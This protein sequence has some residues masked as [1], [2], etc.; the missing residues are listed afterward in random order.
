V[1]RATGVDAAGEAEVPGLMLKDIAWMR[2]IVVDEAD[3]DVH[4]RLLPE[5]DGQIRF[6]IYTDAGG[7]GDAP[8]IHAQGTAVLIEPQLLPDLDLIRLRSECDRISL[9]A[10]QCYQAFNR[11]GLDYGPA[12][13]AIEAVYVGDSKV[14]AK[15]R[16]P[17]CVPPTGAGD[18]ILHPSLMDAALQ[19]TLGLSF[20][21]GD[22]SVS[23]GD[24]KTA[25]PFALGALEMYGPCAA[26]MWAL[27]RYAGGSHGGDTVQ[28]IDLDLCDEHGKVLIRL[29]E[30]SA[31]AL[32][33]EPV[34]EITPVG[35]ILLAPVWKPVTPELRPHT[36]KATPRLLIVGGSREQQ[37]A[38]RDLYPEARDIVLRRDIAEIGA[39]L[40][41]LG[42]I[43]HIVWIAPAQPSPPD[44]SSPNGRG[45]RPYA[46]LIE[47]QEAGVLQLFRLIKALLSH[48]YGDRQ[49]SWT[50][51]TTDAVAVRGQDAVSAAHAAV[52][53]LV[54]SMAKEYPHW[55]VRLVDLDAAAPWPWREL[56]ALPADRNGDAWVQRRGEWFRQEL[57]P[58]RQWPLGES[59]LYR[60]G[61]VYVVIGG[62]GGIGKA[63]SRHIVREHGAQLVWIGRRAEDDA[64][65]ADLDALGAIGP[66]PLYIQADARDRAALQA[67]GERVKAAYGHVHGVVHSA[68]VLLDRTLE[69]MDEARFRTAL[70]TKVDISVRLAEVFAAEPLDFVLFFSAV[71]SFLK[72]PGQSNY[73]AGCTFQDAFAQQLRRAWSCPVKVINWGYWGS[74]GVVSDAFYR[75]RMAAVGIDSI[76]PADGMAALETLF[77]GPLHQLALVK[78]LKPEAMQA[79]ELVNLDAC[80]SVY[81]DSV[82]VEVEALRAYLPGSYP[83]LER[84]KA[85]G[86]PQRDGMDELLI[87]LLWGSLQSL[88]LS[89]DGQVVVDGDGSWPTAAGLLNTYARWWAETVRILEGAGYLRRHGKR[90]TINDPAPIDVDAVW[91]QW[92][93][94]KQEW[95]EDP[96]QKAPVVLVERCLRALPEILTGKRS[97]TDIMFPNGSMELVEGIYQ[98][99]VVADYFNDILGDVVVAY[100]RERLARDGAPG[101]IRILEIGAGTGA[102]TAAVLPKLEPYRVHLREYCYSDISKAF[103]LHAQREYA[104]GRPFLALK[105]F[106]VEQPIAAQGIA[107][108]AYDLAIATNVLHATKNIRRTLANAKAA[109]RKGGLLLLNELNRSALFVHLTFGLLEGWWRYEDGALRL[110]GCPGLAPETWARV[111]REEGFPKLL[112]PAE[113]RHGLGQHIIVAQSDGIVQQEGGEHPAVAGTATADSL[114]SRERAR[115]QGDL[116]VVRTSDVADSL[117][118]RERARVRE[119]GR[120]A[121]PPITSDDVH[122]IDH[123]LLRDKSTALLKRMV[124]ETLNMSPRQIDSTLSLE[125]YGIDSILA[126]RLANAFREV[127]D[128]VSSTLF[129]EVQTIDALVDHFMTT[130]RETLIR[131]VGLEQPRMGAMEGNRTPAATITEQ[132][133]S[134]PAPRPR[135]FNAARR[136]AWAAT[137]VPDELGSGSVVT[138]RRAVFSVQ[139][140]AVIGLS[141][142]YPRARDVG[143]FWQR[144]RAGTNCVGEIPPDRWDWRRFYDAEKGKPGTSYSRWGGFLDDVDMFD[145]LFFQISP[146]E[147]GG[148]DPQERLFLETAY[149]CI[150]DAGYTPATLCSSRKV[151]VFVG[152][153]HGTYSR[154]PSHW[155]IANRVSY[156]FDFHGP[157]LAVNSA[158]SAS[159]TAIHL[160]LESLYAGTSDCAIAGGV[161]LI[162]NPI[163]YLT[164]AS[165]SVLSAG[166]TCRVFGAGADGLVAGEGVGAVLLKPLDKAIADGD[167]I[168]GVLKGSMVNAGGKTNGYTVP[169]PKA[170]AQLVAEAL[171]RA[172]VRAESVSYI[173]AHGT[174]TALGD[175]IEIAGLTQAFERQTQRKQFCAIGSVKSNIGHCESA[176]GIAGLTKVL[177]QMQH[178][179]LVPS[180]HAEVAN[181]HIDFSNTPFVLQRKLSVWNRPVVA[182]AGDGERELPRIAG[183]SSF[184]AGGANAHLV[185][186]EYR[187]PEAI[188]TDSATPCVIVLSARDEDRLKQVAANL[189]RALCDGTVTRDLAAIAY[190]LQVGREAMDERLAFMASSL[191]ELKAGL[192][193]FLNEEE[194]H[195]LTL[196]RGQVNRQKETLAVLAADEDMASAID[197]WIAKGK[198][199]KLLELWVQGLKV[200]WHKLYSASGSGRRRPHRTSLPTYPFARQRYWL[201]DLDLV[202]AAQDGSGQVPGSASAHSDPAATAPDATQTYML[203]P[204]WHAVP[205]EERGDDPSPDDRVLIVGGTEDQRVVLRRIYSEANMLD[206]REGDTIE[207]IATQLVDLE[208]IRHILVLAPEHDMVSPAD[209]ALIR[210]QERGVLL[211]FRLIKALLARGYGGRDLDWTLITIRAQA[212]HVRDLVAPAHATL[213]GL[214]GSMAKEYP[215]WRTRLVDLESAAEWGLPDRPSPVIHQLLRLPPDSAGNAWAYRGGEWFRQEL[216]P[217]RDLAVEGQVYRKNGVYVV[218]GGAGGLGTVWS[219]LMIERYGAHIVWIGRRP[220]DAEIQ[221][222]LDDLA[223]LG[224][225]PL[226]FS[227]D[228]SDRLALQRAYAEIKRRY[229]RIHGVIHAAIVLQD[230]GLAGMDEARF[231]AGLAAKVDVCVRLAQVFAHEDLEFTLFFSSAQSFAKSPGQSNYAAGCT[232]KDAFAKALARHWH[233]RVKV[234]NWGYWGRAGIVSSPE[235]QER[236]QQAG[237]GSIEPEEGMAALNNLLNGPVDQIVLLKAANVAVGTP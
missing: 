30:F 196:Y 110:P 25:M 84:I 96:E 6:E 200:D 176:A 117:S 85:H 83:Q 134:T 79:T 133:R 19:A 126:I 193:A 222:K 63:W 34:A 214:A 120:E 69:N 38:I 221:A 52:H 146:R 4:I 80:L 7:N 71:Q 87:P 26:T 12:F 147:A 138:S 58:V 223:R 78:T 41:A 216:I 28:K 143:E 56:F 189:H 215:H 50:V 43:D 183:I 140:I 116:K 220:K 31:R 94:R 141:G 139:D 132:T 113:A 217:A 16:L 198:Y 45:R 166:G 47:D 9:D 161:N 164:L 106:D 74:I 190:T 40:D 35:N 14:L 237:I 65:R 208:P 191:D 109:L 167:H 175:P 48:G 186:E 101:G 57:L 55:P 157:S 81:P 179:E 173:E 160:A 8:T 192:Q 114:S 135:Q 13:Q 72:A 211:I 61:G 131:L 156:L 75:E 129:F 207:T 95:L 112:F 93:E 127:F 10:A 232:F 177:L 64:I 178:G 89:R 92:E 171:D 111:L 103:L 123:E 2:P 219:R 124:A 3:L 168:Y 73:A 125:E 165:M 88:G 104:P 37:Q 182:S 122:A 15:L 227:A 5:R 230:K 27:I 148:M 151:G 11:V 51:I 130:Q 159:L 205:T 234:M 54:G 206:L 188:A 224:P 142:R 181:P 90:L 236:M 199:E 68:I 67:A 152:V 60:P 169:N 154:Q 76:E 170:Q 225:P 17:A 180:L 24:L 102:T 174:G 162:L 98:G 228:A 70:S 105:L 91:R 82:C 36:P 218:I 203:I 204:A 194:R 202:P 62:A 29:R 121:G 233:G 21:G 184:G 229:S 119:A 158:C 209:E 100:I 144:L 150:E 210:E 59:K 53:G 86:V 32:E 108:G 226:Y 23:S 213:H 77:N 149:A 107:A 39:Q 136:F 97:P 212:V 128:Q 66:R 118:L 201:E 49:L 22:H 99:N 115:A 153:M 20:L 44:E 46:A 231:R 235:Y 187:A 1:C 172:G 137:R 33:G 197:A 185:V 155:S 42:S 195:G 18:L 163:Q 145:P